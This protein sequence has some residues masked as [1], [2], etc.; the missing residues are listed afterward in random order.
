MK[1]TKIKKLLL[2]TVLAIT[3]VAF[4][5]CGQAVKS[6]VAFNADNTVNYSVSGGFDVESW[7]MLAEMSDKTVDEIMKEYE[8]QG[9]TVSEEVIDGLTY[10]L[11]TQVDAMIT[12]YSSIVF[13]YML[14]DRPIAWVLE[15]M[16]HYRVPFLME[17][18]L[19]FMPGNHIYT[20]AQIYCFLEQIY[21]GEDLYREQR[22]AISE[23]YNAPKEGRGCENIARI[24][25]L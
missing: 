21:A 18:P 22:N 19:V 11:L 17:N 3:A 24:L 8:A 20:L 10:K 4:T 6:E 14:L 25:G 16:E 2:T 5:G 13:D 9:A 7:Q 23:Q 1:L 12:D 15:D